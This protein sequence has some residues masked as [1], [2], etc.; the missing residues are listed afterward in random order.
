MG[1]ELFGGSTRSR[2]DRIAEGLRAVHRALIE[3]TRLEYEK[4]HG[5]VQGP[6]ALFTLVAQDPAFAWLRPMTRMIV[7]IEDVLKRDEP[8]VDDSEIAR[9]RAEI[10]R[11]LV[12]EGQAFSIRYLALL[13]SSPEV[14]VENGRL[15]GLLR[16][17][18]PGRP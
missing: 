13:Q 14:A 17:L 5:K 7:D 10:E 18:A 8:P 11:L 15:H 16:S 9:T 1:Q 2:L 12:A 6:Y 4:E 3:A